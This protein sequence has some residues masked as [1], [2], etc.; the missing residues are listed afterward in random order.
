MAGVTLDAG[1]LIL[2]DRNDR[3][4]WKWW[5]EATNVRKTIPAIVVAQV[6]RGP[7]SARLAIVIKGSWIEASGLRRAKLVGELC[8][9]SRVYDVVDVAVVE[10]ASRRGDDIITTD[11]DDIRR[12]V[13][14]T[15]GVGKVVD[16]S[17][18]R[19]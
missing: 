4:F 18:L 9:R 16:I 1:A 14:A 19:R 12:I 6:W 8:G 17:K 10:S 2:A 7:G 13:G 5:A 15:R 3:R 11:P